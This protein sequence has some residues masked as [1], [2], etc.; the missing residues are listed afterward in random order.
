MQLLNLSESTEMYLK[1]L[2]ELGERGDATISHLAEYLGITQVSANEMIK[3]LAEQNLVSHTPYKGV[4]LTEEGRRIACNVIRRQR[5]WECFLHDHLKLDWAHVYE[6]ACDLEHA[7]APEVT[8]ALDVFLGR[9]THCPYG[10]PIPNSDGEFRPLTGVSL[11]TLAVGDRAQV[12]AIQATSTDIL[13]HLSQHGILPNCHV[14][15]L[16]TAPL[17]GPL[18]LRIEDTNV[19]L[20]LHLADLIL[21]QLINAEKDAP[22]HA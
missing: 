20:G 5:L 19:A 13:Q 9:P 11:G 3:R 1:G 2:A 21:V 7:T 12:I 17:Q 4:T 16:E 10:N 18:T 6:L 8:E 15:V 14:T 22:S